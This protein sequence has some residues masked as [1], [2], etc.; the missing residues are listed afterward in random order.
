M[1]EIGKSQHMYAG[2][3]GIKDQNKIIYDNVKM[4]ET[5][6]VDQS[7]SK[8]CLLAIDGGGMRGII[9]ATVL[10]HLEEALKRKSGNP[11]ARIKDYF[12][13]AAGTSV[14]GLLV[15]FLF[16][17]DENGH[18]IFTAEESFKFM[19]EKG[20]DI[21]KFRRAQ[22]VFASLRGLFSPKYSTQFW[23]SVL[24]TLFIRNGEAI[25][26]RDTLKPLII[27]GYDLATAGPV[28]FKTADAI[29]SPSWNFR[30][31]EVIRATSSV[32]GLW[33]PARLTSVDGTNSFA[34]VD[35]GLVLNNPTGVAVNHILNNKREFLSVNSIHDMLILSIGCGQFDRTYEYRK[36]HRWGSL[37]WFKPIA[38]I[39]I[40]SWADMVDFAICT[41]YGK[42]QDNYLRIQV[43]GLPDQ[44]V[45]EV[46]DPSSRN[47]EKLK[48]MGREAL[49]QKTLGYTKLSLKQ[50]HDKSN[51]ERLELFAEALVSERRRRE[52]NTKK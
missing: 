50:L 30:L 36:V 35:G 34:A 32:P 7:R 13:I 6:P 41:M 3:N 31:W 33:K 38:K 18:P 9:A 43:T 21:F 10:V 16:A 46:D 19:I 20:K 29:D 24:Q 17:G 1:D 5:S 52:L 27:P 23:E 25:T 14:G 2:T 11:K 12:D 44:A 42:D 48:K 40:D 37:Q 8:V 47:V 26:M 15:S 45:S 51:K 28:V 4:V 22:R 39:I 49:E